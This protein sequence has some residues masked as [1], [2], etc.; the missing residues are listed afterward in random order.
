MLLLWKPYW[1]YKKLTPQVDADPSPLTHT[2]TTQHYGCTHMA[3]H[4]WWSTGLPYQHDLD[5]C[6]Y[7]VW[8]AIVGLEYQG[9]FWSKCYECLPL[10]FSSRKPGKTYMHQWTGSSLDQVLESYYQVELR[11][12]MLLVYFQVKPFLKTAIVSRYRTFCR[13][14]FVK[15]ADTLRLG[16]VNV[17]D[18]RFSGHYTELYTV[19][20]KT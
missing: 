14:S 6:A 5:I 16:H 2:H 19:Q 8:I 10:L 18:F 12:V 20:H 15:Y 3:P 13:P 9:S 7:C 1:R 11:I 17:L 4:I